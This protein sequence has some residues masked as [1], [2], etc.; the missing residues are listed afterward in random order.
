KQLAPKASRLLDVGA[1]PGYFCRA[2]NEAGFDATGVEI[3]PE[4]RRAGSSRLGVRY[5]ELD[6]V[7]E[8]SIDILTC[9]HVLEHIEW[10][11]DFLSKLRGKMRNN[12][13]FVLHVPN[14]QPLSFLLR[15]ALRGGGD[16]PSSLYYPIHING[17]TCRSLVRTVERQKFKAISAVNAS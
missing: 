2:A 16:T 3:S 11:Q 1:G 17:F 6:E 7:A 5:V 15:Q 9:H 8:A 4:A 12:G 14:Q 13:L 10:P